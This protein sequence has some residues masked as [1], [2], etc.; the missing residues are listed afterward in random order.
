MRT[1]I[2][3]AVTLALVPVVV[4]VVHDPDWASLTTAAPWLPALWSL[5]LLSGTAT[6]T[7]VWHTRLGQ[8]AA[9]VAFIPT[10]IAGAVMFW[11]DLA[12]LRLTLVPGPHWVTPT[13]VVAV[14]ATAG[15]VA[16]L[17]GRR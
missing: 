15:M 2:A 3:V 5:L 13:A 8:M 6:T 1:R 17:L 11:E 12:D 14:Y 16:G 9:V 4:G 10:A 7:R